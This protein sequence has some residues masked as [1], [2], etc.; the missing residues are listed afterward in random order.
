M[1]LVLDDTVGG[2]ASNTYISRAD[3]NTYFEGKYHK[4]AWESASDADKDIVLV[5]ATRVLDAMYIWRGHPT[6]L[7]TPQAL[8]WPR[9]GVL[10]SDGVNLIP[11]DEL[12]DELRWATA[13]LAMS[14]LSGDRTADSDVEVQGLT[15]LKAGSVELGFKD[16]VY[17]KVL[18][19]VVTNYIPSWWGYV[20]TSNPG[21]VPVWRA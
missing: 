3:A 21:S 5:E 6:D 13:E 19:D 16:N 15:R 10:D 12:P 11:E 4:A 8:D 9:T 1:A 20:E 2:S 14:I 17:A 18:P 7:T